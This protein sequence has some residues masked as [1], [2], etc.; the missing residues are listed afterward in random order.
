[1]QTP[2][3]LAQFPS[4][5]SQS[6]TD[7]ANPQRGGGDYLVWQV[8]R[9]LLLAIAVIALWLTIENRWG[10]KF[11]YPTRYEIDS[12]Y[13]LGMMKL[14]AEG[15][16]GLFTHIY[17]K[18]LGAP[19]IGQLNDFPETQRFILWLGGQVARV[20]G[21]MP[22]ANVLMI[23]AA[24]L[25]AFSFY[26]SARLWKMPRDVAWVFALVYAFIPNIIRSLPHVG[27]LFSGL[28]PLQFYVLWYLA[29][30]QKLSWGARRFMIAIS[31][32]FLSGLVNVYWVFLFIHLCFMAFI[33]R[34]VKRRGDLAVSLCPLLATLCVS[35]ILYI[36]FITYG[37]ENGHNANAVVRNYF[38]VELNLLKPIDLFI[39]NIYGRGRLDFIRDYLS[40]YHDYKLPIGELWGGGYNSYMGALSIIGFLILISI[41]VFRIINRRSISLPL[42]V[43]VWL[44]AYCSFGGIHSFISAILGFY[45]IRAT[46]RYSVAISTVSFIYAAFLFYR[47]F[48]NT[49]PIYRLLILLS[50]GA[51][52]IKEQSYNNYLYAHRFFNESI[53]EEVTNDRALV[54]EL[55]T[56]LSINDMIYI[57]PV[58]DFPEP[59]WGRGS[60]KGTFYLYQPMRPFLH[61][62]K[63]R[64]SYGSNKGRQG[65]DWQLDVQELP[66][67]EMATA[68]ESYGFAGILLN[69][70][71]YE[72]RGDQLL[73]ELT[74]AGWPMEFEQGIDNEWVFIPLVP[75]PQP[76]LPTLT[77][78]ALSESPQGAPVPAPPHW[79]PYW[80]PAFLKRDEG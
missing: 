54:Q 43:T 47:V 23:L 32:G 1:M 19:F 55:E 44:I 75:D 35:G 60:S 2:A 21:L 59:Y 24:L 77:P 25:G 11:R 68:L 27:V 40:K 31:V 62:T 26:L 66:A 6:Q 57:L 73:A 36:S 14:S 17:T 9:L 5:S 3:D 39:P 58:T 67:G 52:A 48:R 42:M 80:L 69:R 16:L 7:S 78:Y 33:Y 30:A 65:A 20:I 51:L 74:Q 34:A 15:D 12:H 41:G 46:N 64:Y 29:T 13:I 70:K 72:D 4:H 10:S 56:R 61:S 53:P 45:D 76:V 79:R 37:L 38:E 71:G 22:A 49:M 63:L 18:S 28:L 8:L 50:L